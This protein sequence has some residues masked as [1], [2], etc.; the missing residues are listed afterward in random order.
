MKISV[1][2][3]VYNEEK[4]I[5]KVLEKIKKVEEKLSKNFEIIVINDGSN[6]KTLEYLDN[7]KSLYSKLINIEFNKGKG[8]AINKGFENATGEII[9]IQD[10]DLEYNP[11]EYNKLLLPFEKYDADVVY[12]SRFKSSQMNRVL[13]FWHS[14]INNI[15]TLLSNILS[16]L[17]LTDIETG[18]KL[19]RKEILEKINLEEKRFGIEIEITHKVANLRPKPK[20]FE[21][22][23][24]YFGRTYEEGKKIGIKDAL[25]AFYCIIKFGLITRII[26][27]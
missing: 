20:I 16:D 5:L 21:V 27:K 1:V 22:G 4:T 13:F 25:R 12:G 10:A 17:N 3:P 2:I 9:I 7:N 18:Y 26:K 23:I 8:N 11:E 6:D 15:I 19:F 24:S 14:V